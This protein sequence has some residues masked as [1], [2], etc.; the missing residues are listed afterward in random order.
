M[1]YGQIFRELIE[2][3]REFSGIPQ[4]LNAIRKRIED[5]T[6]AD[7]Q[8]KER[9]YQQQEVRQKWLDKVFA[10]YEQTKGN[11]QT[12]ENRQYGVQNS[13]RWAAW[14]TFVAAALYGFISL[15]LWMNAREQLEIEQRGWLVFD[16]N[17]SD[18]KITEGLQATKPDIAIPFRLVNLGKT[19]I[20][21]I[22]GFVTVEEHP[23]GEPP[24]FRQ[25]SDH[26]TKIRVGIIYPGFDFSHETEVKELVDGGMT[27][28][29]STIKREQFNKGEIVFN[30]W[31]ELSY[32]DVFQRAHWVHFC[33]A[34]TNNPLG[35]TKECADYNRVEPSDRWWAIR[36]V[37]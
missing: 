1:N 18:D 5:H 36:Q 4:S 22:A 35:K 15:L 30:V 8:A 20:R 29:T 6:E 2:R 26:I 9:D 21:A 11:R 12:N 3:F 37:F 32:V 10:E 19:P 28:P 34:I 17:Y 7:N 14:L 33:H 27:V 25:N 31:G 13:L 23:K 16:S 24:A